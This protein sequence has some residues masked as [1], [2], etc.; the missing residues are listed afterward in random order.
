MQE[1]RRREKERRGPHISGP[2]IEGEAQHLDNGPERS[3]CLTISGNPA[4][5]HP[6]V[7][8][9]PNP[10]A[11]LPHPEQ[12]DHT[13]DENMEPPHS[14]HSIYSVTLL[15][16]S[17]LWQ[18]TRTYEHWDKDRDNRSGRGRDTVGQPLPPWT[19]PSRKGK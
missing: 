10:S 4:Q 6:S 5:I 15:V 9:P 2:Q 14:H 19:P 7:S 1:D 17:V 11:H 16:V 8:P 18:R 3:T 13:L 12:A